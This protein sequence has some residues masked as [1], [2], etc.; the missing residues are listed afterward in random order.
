MPI[1]SHAHHLLIVY[2]NLHNKT[3]ENS[4][5]RDMCPAK[6]EILFAIRLFIEKVCGPLPQRFALRQD[7]LGKLCEPS[8]SVRFLT[9]LWPAW[10]CVFSCLHS[11]FSSHLPFCLGPALGLG[12]S[13]IPEHPSFITD[14]VF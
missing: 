2:D 14:L 7:L 13:I 10:L 11:F 1:H 12:L 8:S 6:S 3:E 9:K 4:C 5:H